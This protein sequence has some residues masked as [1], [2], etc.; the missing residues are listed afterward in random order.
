VSGIK[1]PRMFA[2]GVLELTSEGAASTN[3]D[4]CFR[5]TRSLVVAARSEDSAHFGAIGLA[6]EPLAWCLFSPGLHSSLSSSQEVLQKFICEFIC[7]LA[8]RNWCN[9]AR[10]KIND[11]VH[12]VIEW[13]WVKV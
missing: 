10:L 11:G 8:N 9:A 5:V 7:Q 4:S 13:W 3:V 2:T 1:S 6:L 12:A